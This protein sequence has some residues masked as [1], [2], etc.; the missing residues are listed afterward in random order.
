MRGSHLLL[1]YER[2]ELLLETATY[3]MN[4]L[5]ISS[6]GIGAESTSPDMGN[7]C[8]RTFV[9]MNINML[10]KPD[11]HIKKVVKFINKSKYR[12]EGYNDCLD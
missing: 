12:L 1:N 5:I 7:L 10:T 3:H 6:E 8:T 2:K 4:P 11:E 9:V